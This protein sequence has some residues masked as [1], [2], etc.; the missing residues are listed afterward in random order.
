MWLLQGFATLM[1]E[2]RRADLG[3]MYTLFS[4]ANL[5]GHL[6]EALRSYILETGRKILAQGSSLPDF[7]AS[8]DQIWFASFL[9]NTVEQCFM[10]L[11]LSW[12]V[13]KKSLFF[14]HWQ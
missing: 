5:E 7:M 3:R 6:D 4:E 10:E 14:P 13:S 8:V 2:N 1:D 9:E 12:K 11:G